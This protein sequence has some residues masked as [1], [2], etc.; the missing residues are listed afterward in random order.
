[1]KKGVYLNLKDDNADL[2]YYNGKSMEAGRAGYLNFNI[3]FALD[4]N[5]KLISLKF[6]QLV[7]LGKL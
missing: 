2:V 4:L 6:S 3:R 5:K 1:M 7:Y